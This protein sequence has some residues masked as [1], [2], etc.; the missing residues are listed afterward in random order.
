MIHYQRIGL[1]T[2]LVKEIIQIVII[3]TAFKFVG[4]FF[5]VAQ[6]IV[7]IFIVCIFQY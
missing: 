5:D 2:V 6:V 4:S 3:L 7:L 1:F